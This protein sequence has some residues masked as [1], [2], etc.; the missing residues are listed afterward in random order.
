M[1][2]GSGVVTAEVWVDAVAQ[3]R[4]LTWELPCG[5][6]MARETKKEGGGWGAC[7]EGLEWKCYKNLVV[8]IVVHL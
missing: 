5:L 4:F 2:Q 8:M 6:G 1:G 7:T 3:V